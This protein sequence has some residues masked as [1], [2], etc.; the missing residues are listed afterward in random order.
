MHATAA[1]KVSL[2][3]TVGTSVA[4]CAARPAPPAGG[5]AEAAGVRLVGML[6]SQAALAA[7]LSG[8]GLVRAMLAD[9][10]AGE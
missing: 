4:G 8:G 6:A 2:G 10:S 1:G 7:I 3:M 5:M 9:R